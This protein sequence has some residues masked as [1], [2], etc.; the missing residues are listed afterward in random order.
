[1]EGCTFIRNTAGVISAIVS[2]LS[3]QDTLCSLCGGLT[4]LSPPTIL[5]I[6]DPLQTP[7]FS[8]DHSISALIW[9]GNKLNKCHDSIS[10]KFPIWQ[11]MRSP[12]E[13]VVA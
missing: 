2:R 5:D 3:R 7:A 4:Q 13:I 10:F 9:Q 1:M 6:S 12:T 11:V 8:A